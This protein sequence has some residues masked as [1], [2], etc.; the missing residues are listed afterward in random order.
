[1]LLVW[2][3]INRQQHELRVNI[4]MEL[5]PLWT[6]LKDMT[7][8]GHFCPSIETITIFKLTLQCH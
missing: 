3:K 2:K 8:I 6:L 4:N 7:E 1:M 5:T